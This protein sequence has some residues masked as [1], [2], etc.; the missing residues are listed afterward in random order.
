MTAKT[1][2]GVRTRARQTGS[3]TSFTEACRGIFI[4]ANWTGGSA[5]GRGGFEIEAG[6]ALSAVRAS[7]ARAHFAVGGTF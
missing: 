7:G 1:V 4:E 3:M 6:L 2:I 5:L